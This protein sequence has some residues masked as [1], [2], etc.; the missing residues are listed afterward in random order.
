VPED[1]DSPRR[2]TEN[3]SKRGITQTRFGRAIMEEQTN[4]VELELEE[5]T[6]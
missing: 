3:V 6:V 5:Q 2:Y 4:E 1:D